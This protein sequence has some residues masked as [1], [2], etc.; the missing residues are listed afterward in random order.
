MTCRL[1]AHRSTRTISPERSGHSGQPNVCRLIARYSTGLSTRKVFPVHRFVRAAVVLI[2]VL[3]AVATVS[4]LNAQ[5]PTAPITSGCFSD[6]SQA[7]FQ[8]N[9]GAVNC[10]LTTNPGAV[11]LQF[12]GAE[13]ID[14][15]NTTTTV[16]TS[17][18]PFGS[19]ATNMAAQTF[20]PAVSG[21]LTKVDLELF[22]YS[23]TACS[24]VD[25]IITVAIRA[26]TS[27]APSGADLVS[28]TIPG[29]NSGT[30]TYKTATFSSPLSVTA[31]TKYAVVMYLANGLRSALPG[32]D[33]GLYAYMCSC[34]PS[35]NPYANG[36]RYTTTNGSTWTIDNTSG[37]RDLGFKVWIQPPDSYALSGTFTSSLKDANPS[38]GGATTWT[39]IIFGASTPANTTLQMRVAASNSPAGPFTYVGPDGTDNTSFTSG[40]SLEQF[41][42]FRYLRYQAAMTSN[43]S[44]TPTL[45]D[46]VICFTQTPQPLMD[47]NAD[48]NGD[49]FTYNSSSGDWKRATTAGNGTFNE[50]NGSWDPS[51]I[52]TPAKFNTDNNTDVLLFNATSGQWFRMLNNGG[53]GWTVQAF[54]T[55]WPGW[56]RYVMDLNGDG[57][58]DVFLYDPVSGVWFKAVLSTPAG[59]FTYSQGG[60]SPGWEITPMTLNSDAFGDMFL[61]DRTTGRWFWVLGEAGASFTYPATDV[62]FNGWSFYPGDFNADGLSD[63][64]LH[65][66]A[67]GN[68]FVAMNNGAGTGFTYTSGTWSLGWTPYVGDLD[69]DGD[70]D[71]LLHLEANGQWFEML[72]TGTGGFTVGGSGAWSTGWN[73]YPTDFNG[74]A[75]TDFLLYHPTTGV[76]YQARNPSL[77][78]FTYTTGNW[79]TGLTIIAR[80]PFF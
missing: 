9:A 65:H 23:N 45:S 44:N 19:S 76:W 5:G 67:T 66:G 54:G 53:T 56:Q 39:S 78:T 35:T 2:P 73:I 50:V 63:L 48:G 11:I 38:P 27:G 80:T 34:N 40:A 49:V 14:Q 3:I 41:N 57:I 51:W 68:Y 70:Q 1:T 47:I 17:G 61:M 60:W 79:A 37:G 12:G 77:N 20:I 10:D 16:T 62:W 55:W 33:G 31:G 58:S 42:G 30:P 21:L 52:V 18:F 4:T 28:T 13:A 71:L 43:G 64:L 32:P 59:D 22:C 6:T 24:G 75:R 36:Q 46:V 74:D 72:S 15:Q 7:D 26:T 29:F 25:P 8:A 69:A